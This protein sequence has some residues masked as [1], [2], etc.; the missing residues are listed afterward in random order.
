MVIQTSFTNVPQSLQHMSSDTSYCKLEQNSNYTIKCIIFKII[1]FF[2]QTLFARLYL[3]V[4]VLLTCWK[5]MNDRIISP[6]GEI[7]AH[8]NQLNPA[9]F[10]WWLYQA[11]TVSVH[12]HCI[13]VL[14]VSILASFYDFSNA[15]LDCSDSVVCFDFRFISYNKDMKCVPTSYYDFYGNS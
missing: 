3:K 1:A 2:M 4:G 15:F 7:W 13:Y 6:S 9:T 10:Y 11:R 14:G 8:K 12:V 5:H